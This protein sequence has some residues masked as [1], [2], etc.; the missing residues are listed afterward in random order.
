MYF[1]CKHLYIKWILDVKALTASLLLECS[2]CVDNKCR[3]GIM[4][5]FVSL[6]PLFLSICWPALIWCHGYK[7]I[8]RLCMTKSQSNWLSRPFLALSPEHFLSL[9]V[10]EVLSHMVHLNRYTNCGKQWHRLVFRLGC[11]SLVI[12]FAAFSRVTCRSALWVLKLVQ[13]PDTETPR[14]KT[15]SAV[16]IPRY[17]QHTGIGRSLL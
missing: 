2:L 5:P 9:V 12:T 14:A 16:L 7:L 15:R 11:T 8:S 13:I 17:T 6:V 1:V 3:E 4:L 10:L